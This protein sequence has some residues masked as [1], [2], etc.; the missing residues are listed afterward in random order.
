MFNCNYAAL[1][2]TVIRTRFLHTLPNIG[3]QRYNSIRETSSCAP[4]ATLAEGG[5]PVREVRLAWKVEFMTDQDRTTAQEFFRTWWMTD[6]EGNKGVW[7]S[8]TCLQ[9]LGGRFFSTA[10]IIRYPWPFRS[11]SSHKGCSF[12]GGLVSWNLL[13]WWTF[14]QVTHFACVII[15]SCSTDFVGRWVAAG[16]GCRCLMCKLRLFSKLRS[17]FLSCGGRAG[18]D[19]GAKW[20]DAGETLIQWGVQPKAQRVSYWC[21]G[22]TLL[23]QEMF[24]L[25][26]TLFGVGHWADQ[27][28]TLYAPP[29]QDPRSPRSPRLCLDMFRMFWQMVT[30]FQAMFVLSVVSKNVGTS[31]GKT[32]S[33]FCFLARLLDRSALSDFERWV[34]KKYSHY[35]P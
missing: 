6:E 25:S 28:E 9:V 23:L 20:G 14:S 30:W 32:L 10:I 15:M 34:L 18:A 35:Y 2:Q 19:L 13:D 22:S 27:A 7:R 8:Q 11:F 33:C 12:R 1:W 4:C 29:T 16:A 17:W 26:V 31:I 5:H 3:K 21:Q 24:F